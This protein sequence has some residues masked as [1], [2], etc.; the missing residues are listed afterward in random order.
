MAFSLL[1]AAISSLAFV[2][3][4]F[5]TCTI[6]GSTVSRQGGGFSLQ[7]SGFRVVGS[8]PRSSCTRSSPPASRR[9]RIQGS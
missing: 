1:I 7:G 5:S 2:Y 3:T 4:F 8:R 6:E 9:A